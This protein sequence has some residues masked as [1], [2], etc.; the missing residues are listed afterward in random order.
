MYLAPAEVEL[1][2]ATL[3]SAVP[4]GTVLSTDFPNMA[5]L[6][7]FGPMGKFLAWLAAKGA[8]WRFGTDNPRN[9]LELTGWSVEDVVFAGHPRAWPER[10]PFKAGF[11]SPPPGWP[12]NWLVRASRK[13]R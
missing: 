5:F 6:D 13:P 10:M 9:A 4:E 12:A 11:E 3:A 2:L 8:P 1:L 7:P